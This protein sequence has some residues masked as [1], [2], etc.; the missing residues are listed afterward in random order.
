M[1]IDSLTRQLEDAR[2]PPRR[3]SPRPR[4]VAAEQAADAAE[5]AEK[6]I[7]ALNKQLEDAK[8]ENSKSAAAAAEARPKPM[9]SR[10]RRST[11]RSRSP[12]LSP[13]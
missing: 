2:L 13:P 5:A 7:A 6:T 3:N 10:S 1:N 8:A 12:P 11:L 4:K 9:P